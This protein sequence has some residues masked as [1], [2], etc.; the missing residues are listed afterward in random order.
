[1]RYLSVL[2]LLILPVGLASG[3]TIKLHLGGEFFVVELAIS[4]AEKRQGLSQRHNLAADHGMLFIYTEPTQVSFWMKETYIAL[5][6]LFF[7]QKGLL[8]EFYENAQPCRKTPCPL[9]TSRGA[10]NYA[11]ELHAGSS[12]R[13]GLKKGDFF[14]IINN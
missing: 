10:I 6:I 4:A 3:D 8:L 7:D 1:M 2:L 13:L 5:D 14:K 12:Q 11:L 9:F